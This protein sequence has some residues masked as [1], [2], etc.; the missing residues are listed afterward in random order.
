MFRAI[1]HESAAV[2]VR[3]VINWRKRERGRESNLAEWPSQLA[4]LSSGARP[5][6]LLL[7]LLLC[8]SGVRVS[9]DFTIIRLVI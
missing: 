4:N 8:L 5:K 7:L 1:A 3:D 9:I 2:Y 6:T